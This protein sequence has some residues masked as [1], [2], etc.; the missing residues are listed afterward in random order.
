MQITKDFELRPY[1][2]FALDVHCSYF[3]SCS[4]PDDLSVLSRDEYFRSIPFLFVGEGSNLL[5]LGDF[6]GAVVH[7]DGTSI[8]CLEENEQEITLRV[9]AG[10]RWDDLVEYTCQKGW[11]GI[12]NL[13]LIPGET[14]AA[15]AQNIGAYGC[16]ISEVVRCI[17][18]ID[19]KSGRRRCFSTQECRYAYRYSAFKDPEMHYHAIH[20]VDLCLSKTPRPNVSYFPS[21]EETMDTPMEMRRHVIA[22]REAKLPD[23]T[24][25]PNAGSFF[26]NPVV[27]ADAFARLQKKHPHI[28]HYPLDGEVK[29]SAAWLI[30][31]AGYKGKRIGN[32][33]CYHSQPL[34]IVN[35]GGAT[36]E[37]IKDFSDKVR[38]EV[39]NLFDVDLRPEVRF[40]R[41]AEIP[42]ISTS[43]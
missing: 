35:H 43:E 37:E 24:V 38:N 34:V 11:W 29:V 1:N 41:S 3:I 7:Y 23:P 28:P 42:P 12:E 40:V 25:T 8:E 21:L 14:G 17:H 36:A 6:E 27:T 16:E 31:Q 13:S 5:F 32:V 19:L 30:E 39:K 20:A 4:G 18:T 33:G 10:K 15:A 9:E 22:V 2:T 26:T